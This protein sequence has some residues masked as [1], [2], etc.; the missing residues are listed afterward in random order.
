MTAGEIG[1]TSGNISEIS[2]AIVKGDD[3]DD[4]GG[5]DMYL[6]GESAADPGHDEEDQGG[7]TSAGV[8]NGVHEERVEGLGGIQDEEADRSRRH[9]QGLLS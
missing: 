6:I 1:A 9:S 8:S 4:D 5:V 2:S 7:V 3:D